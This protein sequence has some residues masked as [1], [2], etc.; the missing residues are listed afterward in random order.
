MH[1]SA[2]R[3]AH[4]AACVDLVALLIALLVGLCCSFTH[5]L[6]NVPICLGWGFGALLLPLLSRFF[7]FYIPL[8]PAVI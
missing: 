8:L 7:F 1:Y 6:L 5:E 3:A 4:C 2:C